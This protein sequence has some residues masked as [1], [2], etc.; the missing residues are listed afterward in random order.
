VSAKKKTPRVKT[1]QDI[2]TR[3]LVQSRRRC[4][5]CF[6]LAFDTE[7][8]PG[9][10]AHLDQNRSNN[11][12]ANLAWL[13]L[14]HHDQYDSKTSQS[15]GFTEAEVKTFRSLLYLWVQQSVSSVSFG[16]FTNEPSAP[17]SKGR[18]EPVRLEVYD[19]RLTVWHA[20]RDLVGKFVS[21]GEVDRKLLGSFGAST[22]EAHFLFDESVDKF[23][24]EV[25][26]RSFQLMTLDTVLEK[27]PIGDQRNKLVP[28]KMDNMLWLSECLGP[29]K[30]I[31][32]PFL[33]LG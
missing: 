21:T 24:S 31:I 14:S 8:K 18:G 29:L 6:C 33:W 17:A 12:L 1:P 19:R 7:R 27:I 11:D 2:E 22:S 25:Y 5:I 9:Q 28:M 3:L 16:G 13:C 4:A 26:H 15:K 32:A 30:R 23:L 20:A 10:I